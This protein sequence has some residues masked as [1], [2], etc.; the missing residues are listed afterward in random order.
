MSNQS[1]FT[2]KIYVS[3][4]NEIHAGNQTDP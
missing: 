1:F 3:S 2:I 4:Q